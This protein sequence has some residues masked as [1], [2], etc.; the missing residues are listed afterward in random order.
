MSPTTK[1]GNGS[2]LKKLKSMWTIGRFPSGEKR[3]PEHQEQYMFEMER[4]VYSAFFV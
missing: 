2:A 3:N 4:A 1:I